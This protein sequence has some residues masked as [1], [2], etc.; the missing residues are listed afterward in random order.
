MG[1]PK[2][3]SKAV[4]ERL[5]EAGGESIFILELNTSKIYDCNPIAA[6]RLGY[7]RE[8]ILLMDINELEVPLSEETT[9]FWTSGIS[10]THYYEAYMRHKDGTLLPVEVNSRFIDA[11]GQN[12]VVNFIRDIRRRKE[13]EVQREQ[14]ISD[15]DSFAHMVAHDLKNPINTIMGYLTL[16]E[17]ML[18]DEDVNPAQLQEYFG[19]TFHGIGQMVNIIDGLLVFASLRD[20]EEIETTMLDMNDVLYDVVARVQSLS[21]Q[22]NAT[23]TIDPNI[24][25]ARGRYDWVT[26]IWMNY[27]TNAIKYGGEPPQILISGRVTES[28]MV[29]YSVRDNGKGI[30]E[31]DQKRVFKKHIRLENVGTKGQGLGLSIVRRIVQRLGGKTGLRSKEGQGSTFYFSLPAK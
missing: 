23:I 12:Y 20:G 31:E 15:L 8:E 29:S 2:N 5:Y 7:T 17:D 22:Y 13:A 6:R 14:L 27:I 25:M 1:H 19:M 26:E 21:N 16:V 18:G 11:E 24:P 30:S 9:R 3:I 10:D 28:G 4:Y